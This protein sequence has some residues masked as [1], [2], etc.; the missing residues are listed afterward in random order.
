MVYSFDMNLFHAPKF[1]SRIPQAIL[2]LL[3]KAKI[4]CFIGGWPPNLLFVLLLKVCL[5]TSR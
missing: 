4:V 3:H 5:S 2:V 1:L